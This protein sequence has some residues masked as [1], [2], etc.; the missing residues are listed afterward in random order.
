MWPKIS[1]LEKVTNPVLICRQKLPLGFTIQRRN[2]DAFR[3][4][5]AVCQ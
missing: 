5:D 3:N 4:V 2:V 1:K